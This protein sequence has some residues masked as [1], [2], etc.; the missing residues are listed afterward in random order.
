MAGAEL[1]IRAAAAED[2]PALAEIYGHH[3]LHGLGTFEEE[4]PSLEEMNQRRASVVEAGLP[5]LVAEVEGAVGGFAYVV[6]F[7]PRAAYRFTVENSVYVAP[8]A[9]GR[10]VGRAL[11]ERLI[12]DCVALGKRR[13]GEGEG[14]QAGGKLHR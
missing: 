8:R 7:R 2:A 13:G 6:P 9:I 3:V 12:S 1:R 11:L 10:G 14:E 4:A 5:Y